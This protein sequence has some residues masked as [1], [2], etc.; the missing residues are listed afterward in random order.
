M[1][2]HEFISSVSNLANYD[3]K[4]HTHKAIIIHAQHE[5]G[6][7]LLRY[8]GEIDVNGTW[9]TYNSF[10]PEEVCKSLAMQLNAIRDRDDLHN[11]MIEIVRTQTAKICD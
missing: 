7:P 10:V 6:D 1:Q 5:D 9:I 3:G 2:W 4:I 8:F 11:T